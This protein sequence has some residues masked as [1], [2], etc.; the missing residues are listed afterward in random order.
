MKR[1]FHFFIFLALTMAAWAESD[2]YTVIVSLD[3]LRWDYAE[4]FDMPFFS[5]LCYDGVKAVMEPSY[6]SKTFPNHYTLA[7]G[8]YPDHHGLIGNSF[9]NRKTGEKYSLSNKD[10]RANLE[11][12]GGEP[13]WL[14][15]QRQGLKTA[16]VYWVGS[17]IPIQGKYP[18]YWRDYQKRPLLKFDERVN[19]VV[20]HLQKPEKDR[21]RLIM[22]YF[23]EPDHQGHGHGPMSPEVRRSVEYLDSLL[24]TLW[25][26][27]K[28]L[29]EVGNRVNLII[30]GDHGMTWLSNE[31]VIHPNDYLKQEWIEY[32]AGDAPALVY[33][34]R[35]E[36][37]DI[38]LHALHGVP[39]IRAYRRGQLPE[40]LHYGTDKNMGDVVVDTDPGWL[41]NNRETVS[42]KGGHGFDSRC[43]DMLVGFRAVG[44]DF[45]VG[46]DRR[47]TFRN[48]CIYPLLCHLLG[49]TPAPNDGS[50][51]EVSDML[52]VKY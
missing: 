12:Y 22:C 20:A 6:P 46:Y 25:L 1:L 24:Y 15:A 14:T 51:D 19:E 21:P 29:P 44:P 26:K 35:E 37:T 52:R 50:L 36:Y 2:N 7:T 42:N 17:D 10:A 43:S 3:G 45:K 13:I 8:L 34:T 33:V 40:Y 4:A 49:I 28:A 23:N 11:Y 39:H 47:A 27:I 9:R 5:Q 32:I 30:T 18:T 16:T 31:R 41:F 48:V 38:V